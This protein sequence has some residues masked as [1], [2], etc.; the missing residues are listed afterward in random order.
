MRL[1]ALD[2]E[3]SDRHYIRTGILLGLLTGVALKLGSLLLPWLLSLLT[4]H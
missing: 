3:R 4:W 1:K 2:L